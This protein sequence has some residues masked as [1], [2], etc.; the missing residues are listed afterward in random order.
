M[1]IECGQCANMVIR[2]TKV[3]PGVMYCRLFK[4]NEWLMLCSTARS[5][6][7]INKGARRCGKGALFFEPK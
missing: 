2:D 7:P 3:R 5:Y 6:H 1:R 4:A